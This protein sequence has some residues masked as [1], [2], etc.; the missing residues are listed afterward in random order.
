MI[1]YK[2]TTQTT[3][4]TTEYKQ[5][6]ERAQEFFSVL[7]LNVIIIY[8][9]HDFWLTKRGEKIVNFFYI[10]FKLCYYLSNTRR[11]EN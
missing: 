4:K 1:I 5:D 8:A 11:D 2:N 9:R 7:L 10:N 3:G 6:G